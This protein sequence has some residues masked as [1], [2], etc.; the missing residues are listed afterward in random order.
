M[1]NNSLIGAQFKIGDKIIC[2]DNSGRES[3]LTLDKIYNVT[4]TYD[5]YSIREV[6]II[7]DDFEKITAYSCRFTSIKIQRKEKL[8]RIRAL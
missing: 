1:I 6:E 5:N 7:G 3:C 8:E 4:K 2:V